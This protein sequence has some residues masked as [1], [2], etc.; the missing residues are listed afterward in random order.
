MKG[1]ILMGLNGLFLGNALLHK[2]AS[3]A[4]SSSAVLRLDSRITGS[5]VLFNILN[6]NTLAGVL[7]AC[8]RRMGSFLFFGRQAL[9]SRSHRRQSRQ[10]IL[11]GIE[12]EESHG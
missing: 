11:R 2:N 7:P 8:E 6:L 5:T 10:V 1:V 9:D 12:I 3:K 4:P